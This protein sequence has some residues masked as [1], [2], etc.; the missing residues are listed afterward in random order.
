MAQAISKAKAQILL[1]CRT[2][3][4]LKEQ[5]PL[6][7]AKENSVVPVKDFHIT[8]GIM[9]TQLQANGFQ[10]YIADNVS[11]EDYLSMLKYLYENPL[12]E[13]VFT[14]I[15]ENIKL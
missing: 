10:L 11:Y 15:Q 7:Y 14:K 9:E 3:D 6:Q 13:N 1:T 12:K 4:M 2:H 8:L 5:F